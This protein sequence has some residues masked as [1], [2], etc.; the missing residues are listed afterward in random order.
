[1]KRERAFERQG[2]N[3][4]TGANSNWNSRKRGGVRVLATTLSGTDGSWLSV[5]EGRD[6]RGGADE[7]TS[8]SLTVRQWH[9]YEVRGAGNWA[10]AAWKRSR[11][12]AQKK[13]M[14]Q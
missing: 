5:G 9:F 10:N 12:I 1:M 7:R 3:D 6:L 11:S 4:V 2:I 8:E 14:C 13:Q